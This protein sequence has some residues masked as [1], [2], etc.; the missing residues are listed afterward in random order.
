MVIETTLH[1]KESNELKG[2]IFTNL[3]I[4]GIGG[5]GNKGTYKNNIPNEPKT[6]PLHV[7]E[8]TTTPN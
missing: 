2:K 3:F 6:Q 7:A 8:E 1:D 4:R 5:F